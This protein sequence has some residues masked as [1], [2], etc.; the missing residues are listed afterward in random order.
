MTKE[1]A[2]KALTEAGYPAA[3]ENGV[4]TFKSLVS[5]ADRKKITKE[6]KQI[7]YGGSYGWREKP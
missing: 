4:I 6:M 7:G 5:K 1:E 3:V 2:A